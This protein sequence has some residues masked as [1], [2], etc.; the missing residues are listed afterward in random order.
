MTLCGTQKGNKPAGLRDFTQARFFIF[1]ELSK[2]TRT[3]FI[4][5]ASSL[6]LGRPQ[7]FR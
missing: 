7:L 2:Y 1:F 4:R 3:A 5:P 6:T